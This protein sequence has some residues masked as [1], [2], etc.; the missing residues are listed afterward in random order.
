MPDSSEGIFA[1][2]QA[3]TLVLKAI[4]SGSVLNHGRDASI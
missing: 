4:F 3:K 2:N 1:E